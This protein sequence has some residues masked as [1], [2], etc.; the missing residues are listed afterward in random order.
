MFS[1]IFVG[2]LFATCTVLLVAYPLNKRL[3]IQ[4]SDELAERRRKSALQTPLPQT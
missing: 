1:S 2:I 3:T 4:I